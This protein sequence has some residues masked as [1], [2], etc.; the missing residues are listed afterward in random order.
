MGLSLPPPSPVAATPADL[1]RCPCDVCRPKPGESICGPPPQVWP[2]PMLMASCSVSCCTRASSSRPS[3]G[4][5]SAKRARRLLASALNFFTSCV[6]LLRVQSSFTRS[7]RYFSSMRRSWSSRI[8]EPSCISRMTRSRAVL[9]FTSAW[10]R[11]RSSVVSRCARRCSSKALALEAASCLRCSMSFSMWSDSA[12]TFLFDERSAS[13]A[14]YL[15]SFS[16][17]CREARCVARMR[18]AFMSSAVP[19]SS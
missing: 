10:L 3:P 6:A 8:L 18:S 9:R 7:S 13:S 2:R 12:A 19:W 16:W 4:C 15:A 5:S 17:R 11:L 14:R 1:L